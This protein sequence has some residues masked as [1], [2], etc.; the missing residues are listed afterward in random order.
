MYKRREEEKM[1]G[2]SALEKEWVPERKSDG[3]YRS[4]SAKMHPNQRDSEAYRVLHCPDL[5]SFR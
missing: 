3:Y 4:E 5:A 2:T 1:I